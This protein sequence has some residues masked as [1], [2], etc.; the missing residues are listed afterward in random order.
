MSTPT[1]IGL[2]AG[3]G[4]GAGLLI[5]VASSRGWSLADRFASRG[6]SRKISRDT[7]LRI[8]IAIVAF[9]IVLLV[10]RWIVA[11]VAAAAIV[12]VWPYLFGSDAQGRRD[13]AY[14]DGLAS[15][16]ESLRDTIAGA[17]GLEQAIP[18]TTTNAPA[19]L[20]EPLERLV[21]RLRVRTPLAEALSH[22][23]DDIDDRGAD[24]VIA[25]LILNART[26][27]PGLRQSL[28]ALTISAREELEQRQRQEARR[29]TVRNSAR[30]VV[31]ITLAF[32]LFLKVF[33]SDFLE[34]Y[35]SPFGQL[36]LLVVFGIFAAG[37]AWLRKLSAPPRPPRF[38]ADA[39]KVR[40]TTAAGGA[41]R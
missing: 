17:I 14:L 21:A 30:L 7:R 34:P 25:S 35:D 20:A 11:A 3:L 36:M 23:A 33:A 5:I 27:G 19:V 26:R 28:G 8:G 1:L 15:W 9:L 22:L 24:L 6:P 4:L 41:H 13:L 32:A 37:F 38:L 40:A 39:A 2:L 31:V 18:A 10:T 12:V 16:T 29:R